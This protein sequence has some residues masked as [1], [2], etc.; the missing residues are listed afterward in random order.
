MTP[1]RI[2]VV[3]PYVQPCCD[4]PRMSEVF[5]QRWGVP[6]WCASRAALPPD[7]F[8]AAVVWANGASQAGSPQ[9]VAASARRA[10]GDEEDV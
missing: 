4:P 5:R 1:T 3:S 8:R 7:E 10:Y 2:A 9:A 6:A